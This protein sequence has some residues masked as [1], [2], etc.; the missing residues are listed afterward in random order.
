MLEEKDFLPDKDQHV[1]NLK[2][3]MTAPGEVL[4]LEFLPLLW[5]ENGKSVW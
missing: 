4:L 2:M 1:W 3:I 5:I